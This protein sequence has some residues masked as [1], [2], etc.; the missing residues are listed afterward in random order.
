VA[1]LALALAACAPLPAPQQFPELTYAQLGAI[2]L[3]VARVE[4]VVAYDPPLAPPNV[5]HTFPTTP[6]TAAERWALDR[7][8]ALGDAGWAQFIVREAGVTETAIEV[9]GGLKGAFTEDQSERYEGV[10]DVVLEIRSDRGF[11]DAYVEARAMRTRTVS[12][13]ITVNDRQRVFFEMTKGLMADINAQLEDRIRQHLS[14]YL[15]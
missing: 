2:R 10:L 8:R 1:P 9:E 15:R 7:I 3:D 12:E 5:E 11:R 4:I 6:A 14:R 13:D